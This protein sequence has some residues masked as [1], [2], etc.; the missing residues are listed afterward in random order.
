MQGEVFE[1]LK[2][3]APTLGGEGAQIADLQRLSGGA[4][5]QT[6]AFA[7]VGGRG[8]DELILRRRVGSFDP[9]A[10]RSV[11]LEVE[12]ALITAAEKVGAPVAPLVH[13]ARPQ[14]GLGEAHITR[15]ISG[16]TLGR[17]IVSD[18]RFDAVRPALA[19]QCGAILA[20]I[21]SAQ[22]P[23]GLKTVD[24][25]AE[26]ARYEEIYRASGAERPILELAFQHLKKRAPE[27]R[28]AVLLHGDFRNGNLMVDPDKGVAAV[29]DWEL[30]HMGDPA[31]DL[32]WI[33]VNSWRFGRS[34]RPV[35]GFGEYRDLLD[36]YVEAGGEAIPLERVL[37]WQALGSLKWGVMCLMMYASYANGT[38]ASVERP[39]IGRRV[40]ETEIDLVT[41]LEN[42]L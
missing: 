39:M 33:C 20:Q 1:A 9:D 4:S 19:R 42:G 15:R 14:D 24:A 40:S 21:H 25:L 38:D 41:L 34:D 36:G 2:G 6:W 17:K 18:P 37:Y 10:A 16:E 11:S 13:L 8:R 5:M 32:G 35:G 29:L 22:P 3:L 7:V 27:P 12:A 23:E 31:E 30:S 28:P 26:L